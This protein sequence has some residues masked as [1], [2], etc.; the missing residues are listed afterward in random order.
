[1]VN[2]NLPLGVKVL[3]QGRALLGKDLH[4]QDPVYEERTKVIGCA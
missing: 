1:M 4:V 2:E 3:E